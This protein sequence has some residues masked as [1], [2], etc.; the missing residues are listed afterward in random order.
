MKKAACSILAGLALLFTSSLSALAREPYY[1]YQSYDDY[2]KAHYPDP[3]PSKPKE[4][5]PPSK[6]P[7]EREFKPSAKQ[8]LLVTQAPDF[9]FPPEL[10]FGV[11]IGVPYDMFYLSGI[12]YY[13][14]SG[15]WHRSP[16][17]R[18][19]WAVVGASQ[20]PAKLRKYSL[21]R[22]REFRN[23]EFAAFWKDKARYKGK[24]YHPGGEAQE[25]PQKGR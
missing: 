18:G 12:Y 7:P 20:L 9:L 5:P 21:V 25:L 13:L 2:H 23:R 3:P 14:Q 6:P 10:D 4:P 8:P 1:P 11:A 19:P 15:S 17:Y 16:S 22:I 24:V